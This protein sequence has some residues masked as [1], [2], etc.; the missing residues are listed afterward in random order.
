ML[1]KIIASIGFILFCLPAIS[2]H[3][4]T[5]S[6]TQTNSAGTVEGQGNPA[7]EIDTILDQSVKE[8]GDKEIKSL[9]T[10]LD[11]AME[12]PVPETDTKKLAESN[13]KKLQAV[14]QAWT[15]TKDK[16]QDSEV[17]AGYW[18]KLV[19]Y[20]PELPIR[21]L[22][23]VNESDKQS[24]MVFVTSAR[25]YATEVYGPDAVA[26]ALSKKVPE[27]S[28]ILIAQ[29]DGSFKGAD[30]KAWQ[31]ATAKTLIVSGNT[32]STKF[33]Q[34][35]TS[36]GKTEDA[37]KAPELTKDGTSTVYD[38]LNGYVDTLQKYNR[39]KQEVDALPVDAIPRYSPDN[40]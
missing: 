32:A 35:T 31:E 1:M 25:D 16:L 9:K 10:L 18:A 12:K 3:A 20:V 8:S 19:H 21:L 15:V 22:E 33:G 40:D 36:L 2:S 26:I 38:T 37:L 34:Q 17:A 14:L 30:I 5:P 28:K 24:A 23:N 7:R 11:K 4:Q 27:V 13:K 39:F 6:P 29:S